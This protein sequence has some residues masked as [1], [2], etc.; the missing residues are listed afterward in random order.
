MDCQVAGDWPKLEMMLKKTAPTE[1]SEGKPETIFKKCVK[2][3]ETLQDYSAKWNELTMSCK[4]VS[5]SSG[6]DIRAI[7]SSFKLQV[8]E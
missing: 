4:S 8:G 7:S 3:L 1:P 5:A 2:E 6:D